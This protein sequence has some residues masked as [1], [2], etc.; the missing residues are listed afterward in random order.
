MERI[1]STSFS[2]QDEVAVAIQVMQMG[3]RLEVIRWNGHAPD[4]SAS[5]GLVRSVLERPDLATK[6]AN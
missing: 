5:P 3:V 4:L 6:I 2:P 1:L